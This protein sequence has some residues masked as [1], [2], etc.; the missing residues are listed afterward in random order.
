MS[1]WARLLVA[2]KAWF[3]HVPT[4]TIDRAKHF[5]SGEGDDLYRTPPPGQAID[6][7]A[8]VDFVTR[9]GPGHSVAR[10]PVIEC[11]GG[12]AFFAE[13]EERFKRL[14]DAEV[15]CYQVTSEAVQGTIGELARFAVSQGVEQRA[16]EIMA[17]AVMQRQIRAF[18]ASRPR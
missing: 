16:F 17:A 4:G 12:N 7:D 5:W 18:A 1:E 13:V 10:G 8:K 9:G 14:D 15:R 6:A 11:E 2:D 3:L